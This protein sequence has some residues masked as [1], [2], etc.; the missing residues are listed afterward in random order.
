[1]DPAPGRATQH[2]DERADPVTNTPNLRSKAPGEPAALGVPAAPKKQESP[3]GQKQRVLLADDPQSANA[4]ATRLPEAARA[5]ARGYREPHA[6][7]AELGGPEAKRADKDA[8]G[9]PAAGL[10]REHA[11]DGPVQRHQ[12]EEPSAGGGRGQVVPSAP[13]TTP[14]PSGP[15]LPVVTLTFRRAN[16]GQKA[17]LPAAVPEAIEQFRMFLVAGAEAQSPGLDPSMFPYFQRAGAPQ[18]RSIPVR[19]APAGAWSGFIVDGLAGGLPASGPAEG[20]R[21]PGQPPPTVDRFVGRPN[22][23]ASVWLVEG[24]P[25]EVRRLLGHVGELARSGTFELRTSEVP[26]AAL[27][28]PDA[29]AAAPGSVPPEGK[30][31]EQ[32]AESRMKEVGK[33]VE[34]R[35]RDGAPPRAAAPQGSGPGTSSVSEQKAG[36]A[37]QIRLLL[38]LQ[39]MPTAEPAPE[40]PKP[41]DTPP[42]R[43][44]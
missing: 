17:A 41:V 9:Q 32:R 22:Q 15:T 21:A 43:K 24:R 20:Q 23:A 18:L 27:N 4:E 2:A 28:L 11:A 39:S 13:A 5:G 33:A 30:P 44:Q 19:S 42:P 6:P 7:G 37:D 29:G 16:L 40:L 3:V 14:L 10:E 34:D 35:V 25:D 38:V 8:G 36:V 26:A 1:M 31:A 12:E